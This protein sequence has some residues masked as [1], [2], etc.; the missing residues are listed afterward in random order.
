MQ[1]D[2]DEGNL[3]HCTKHGVSKEEIESLFDNDPIIIDD[4]SHSGKESRRIAIGM[5]N[6]RRMFV[7]YT[8]RMLND[9]IAIRP[10]TARY[11][12]EK[13]FARRVEKAARV[14]KR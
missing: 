12:H 10:I 8:H 9:A 13:N 14:Q 11:D 5:L 4:V 6:G 2:W 1:F 3:E 7:G